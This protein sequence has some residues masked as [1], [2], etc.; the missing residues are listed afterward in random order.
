MV[1]YDITDHLAIG[2]FQTFSNFQVIYNTVK[3][4]KEASRL[5]YHK[6]KCEYPVTV[7][8]TTLSLINFVFAWQVSASGENSIG[9]CYLRKL[10]YVIVIILLI[11]FQFKVLRFLLFKNTL[12]TGNFTFLSLLC[13]QLCQNTQRDTQIMI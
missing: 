10:C 6:M 11:S 4:F 5:I 7:G 13:G 9:Y 12:S 8:A 2:G 1:K 3:I